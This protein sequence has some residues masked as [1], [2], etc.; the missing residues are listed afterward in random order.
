VRLG[1][2][3]IKIRRR[4][5]F[6]LLPKFADVG[7]YTPAKVKEQVAAAK[8]APRP[9]LAAFKRYRLMATFQMTDSQQVTMSVA[10]TDKKG[11]PAP[12]PAG[13]APPQ[14]L[15]DNAALLTLT[16]AADGMSCVVAA[17]GP[18]GD[19]TVSVKV[20]DAAGNS[21]ATGSIA[22]TIVGG[23]PVNIAITPGTPSEQP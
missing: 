17:T 7:E 13:A 18:L 5:R 15:V 8:P 11:N 6:Q 12:A 14:W 4:R 21:L 2:L 9:L 3:S 22:V 20:T 1:P 23:A 16:P 19:G 10:F